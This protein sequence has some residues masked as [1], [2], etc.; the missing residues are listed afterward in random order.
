MRRSIIGIAIAAAL[1]LGT[2]VVFAVTPGDGGHVNGSMV[3]VDNSLGDQLDPHV[4][5]DLAAYTDASNPDKDVIRYYDFL[6]P[7]SPNASIPS[8]ADDIDTLSDIDGNHIAFARYDQSL[9]TRACM[10]YDVT[11]NTT[12]QIG[13]GTQAF[14]TALAADTVSITIME[15]IDNP[16]RSP[17]GPTAG[18]SPVAVDTR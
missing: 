17:S 6:S 2:V 11:S 12:I 3:V 4:S 10:V 5:G 7:V 8:S 14:A 16:I 13:S 18:R 9:G 1:A 15:V